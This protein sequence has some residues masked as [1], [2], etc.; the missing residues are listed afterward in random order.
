MIHSAVLGCDPDRFVQA[1]PDVL[2]LDAAN[3]VGSRPNGWWRDRA[4]ATSNFVEKVRA[5]AACP[6][7]QAGRD[8]FSRV[9]LDE[10]NRKAPTTTC[11]SSNAPGPGDEALVAL[12]V[13]ATEA[14]VLVSADRALGDRCRGAGADVV[15]PSWLLDRLES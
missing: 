3:V 14:V 2:L 9:L 11:W 1:F 10:S 7:A 4:K 15:R 8:L 13:A 5:A 12:A 6:G